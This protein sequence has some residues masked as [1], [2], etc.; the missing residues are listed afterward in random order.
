MKQIVLTILLSITVILLAAQDLRTSRNTSYYTYIY[1]LTEKQAEKI[2]RKNTEKADGSYLTQL[3]DSFSTSKTYNKTLPAGHYLHIHTLRNKLELEV[4]SVNNVKINILNNNRD[5]SIM[6]NDLSGNILSDANIKLKNKNIPYN[7]QTKTYLSPYTNRKG[8]LKITYQGHINYYNLKADYHFSKFKI[9]TNKIVYR[10]PLKYIAIPVRI[11]F[12]IPY[13]T[14]R[15]CRYRRPNGFYYFAYKPVGDIAKSIKWGYPYGYIGSISN[16]FKARNKHYNGYLIFNKPKYLPGDTIYLKAYIV[17]E[18]NKPIKDSLRIE[19]YMDEYKPLGWV[20]PY[21]PGAYQFKFIA[22]KNMG[23]KLD[24]DYS[25]SLKKENYTCI[26]NSFRFE[27]YELKSTHYDLRANKKDYH[28]NEPVTFYCK[29]TDENDL[30]L[31]D[32]RVELILLKKD[33]TTYYNNRVFIPD[34]LWVHKQNLDPLGE[35]KIMVPDSIFP[36]ASVNIKVLANFLNSN[37]ELQ[38]RTLVLSKDNAQKEI[39]F[40]ESGDSLEIT[41]LYKGKPQEKEALLDIDGFFED[42]KIIL[43]FKDKIIPFA[44]S[45]DVYAD[46]IFN[47]YDLTEAQANVQCFSNRDADTVAFSIDNPRK[48][49]LTYTIF[50]KNK[51]IFRGTGDNPKFKCSSTTRENYSASVQYIWGGKP[52]TEEYVIPFND[53]QLKVITYQPSV[54]YPGQK[55]KINL[56]VTDAYGKP[57]PN[58]DITALSFTK[59]FTGH[60]IPDIPY[61]GKRYANRNKFNNFES[62]E[63]FGQLEGKKIVDWKRWNPIFRLDSIELYKFLYPKN[64]FYE[65]TFNRTDTTFAEVSPFLCDSIGNPMPINMVYIDGE[66]VYYSVTTNNKPYVFRVDPGYHTIT[67]RSTHQEIEINYVFLKK[68]TKTILCINPFIKNPKYK[69]IEKSRWYSPSEQSL[70]QSSV[71]TIRNKFGNSFAYLQQGSNFEIINS[72]TLYDYNPKI[73]GPYKQTNFKYDMPSVF[74]IPTYFEPGFEYEFLPNLVKMRTWNFLHA[75]WNYLD[76]KTPPE[77]FND[78]I[79]T[80]DDILH[81]WDLTVK[82]K[83]SKAPV[84]KNPTYT[85]TGNGTLIIDYKPDTFKIDIQAKNYL[86]FSTKD[87]DFIRVY[88][89]TEKTVYNLE[90]GYY[91]L[92]MI[93]FNN[94]YLV[95]DSIHIKPNGTNYCRFSARNRKSNNNYIENIN[96]IIQQRLMYDP[97]E[98]KYL[99]NASEEQNRIIELAKK[100]RKITYNSTQIITGRVFDVTTNEALPGVNIILKGTSTGTITDIDGYFNLAIPVGQHQ[101]TFSYIG[102]TSEELTIKQGAD[103]R[104]ALSPDIKNLDEVVVIGYGVQKMSSLTG[105][106]STI[107]GNSLQGRLAGLMVDSSPNIVIRGLSSL[108]AA[109]SPLVVI[110]GIPV[111]GNMPEFK[112]EEIENS[113]IIKDASAVALYG[114]RAANGVII[115]TTKKKNGNAQLKNLMQNKE[116]MAGLTQSNSLRNRFSDYAFWKPDLTTNDKGIASFEVT[117]PDDITAWKTFYLAM[118]NKATSGQT[119]GEIK[120]FK[121]IASSLAL[122]RFLLAGDRSNLIGKALNYTDDSIRVKTTF[123]ID[124]SV[125]YCKDGKILSARIDTFKIVTANTDSVKVKYQLKK[126]D[127]YTDGELRNIPV[128]PLGTLETKGSFYNLESDTTI[129]LAFDK[130]LG[131]VTL[132]AEADL[133]NVMLDEL[134]RLRNYQHFCNEQLSSIL[135]GMLW[136]RKLFQ[137]MDKEYKYEGDIRK[138]ILLLEERRNADSLWGWWQNGSTS[139]WITLHASEAIKMAQKAGFNTHVNFNTI[140]PK[141]YIEYPKLGYRDQMRAVKL[142]K[143]ID[144]IPAFKQLIDSIHISKYDT[145]GQ[146]ELWEL[147]QSFGLKFPSDSLRR[148]QKVTQFGNLYWGAEGYSLFDDAI[149]ATLIAYRIL[150]HENPK[151]KQLI[152]IRNYFLERKGDMHWRNTW[153]TCRILE[154]ILPDLIKNHELNL[155]PELQFT[156]GY[157]NTVNVFPFHQVLKPNDTIYVTKKSEAPVYFTAYQQFFNPAPEKITK[158]FIVTSRFEN[159]SSVLKAGKPVKLIVDVNVKKASEY[160]MIEIPIPAGCTYQDKNNF[161][162]GEDY[163]EYFKE[164]VSIYC[165]RMAQHKYTFEVNLLP[166]YNG[167]Y[168]LNPAKAELM[169]FPVFY[170]RET[171]KTVKID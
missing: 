167:V 164:K 148:E 123:E 20:K 137:L 64:G 42:K 146:Y 8:L 31:T 55:T 74:S 10:S 114:S 30:V 34:T 40:K 35:T 84:Y 154:T 168:H 129:A 87:P 80:L 102:Y 22:T 6:V 43:P 105:S 169:Y 1:K 170:G 12:N 62:N 106:V 14:Y 115:I 25:I 155:K 54:V 86:L 152:K 93:L 41:F 145:A 113:E 85:L 19:I 18:K 51:P 159:A 15:L 157:K 132:H 68:G 158:D 79:N 124:D 45:Y 150:R 81:I 82:E 144:S 44:I 107:T 151:N 136:E 95:V 165:S 103:V 46:S 71:F 2:Y 147:K 48:L 161:V 23:L 58:A 121:P 131:K 126:D 67:I 156:G 21:R 88:P 153:E 83:Q 66:P 3:I 135:K 116:F 28:Y 111:T 63:D 24:M 139:W 27:E 75:K 9:A 76:Y 73:V 11:V 100:S 162:C 133:I 59:K 108:N 89:G 70:I 142:L 77:S 99:K 16:I 119:E 138:V 69:V 32:A 37:N 57:V 26:S 140:S 7:F 38:Q 52:K 47:S 122:P 50:R 117:F 29:G 56:V 130:S 53:K 4:V 33:I 109:N 125:Q 96:S 127:G 36:A 110:D 91:R 118:G 90:A 60:N 94:Q 65:Y 149:S 104:V 72:N 17:D 92:E 78:S 97:D 49:P 5:L 13:D 134:K 166:R 39:V 128:F 141:I 101:L 143:N 120:S 61:F 171:L 112:P 98:I 160:V 163:R